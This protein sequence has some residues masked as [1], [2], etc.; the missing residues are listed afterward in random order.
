MTPQRFSPGFH[1][2]GGSKARNTAGTSSLV[3]AR[4]RNPDAVPSVSRIAVSSPWCH[5]GRMTVPHMFTAAMHQEEDWFVAQCLEVDVA[6]QGQTIP[7]ALS[8]WTA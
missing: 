5:T 3:Q 4:I 7:E 1:S 2:S 8:N 6:S